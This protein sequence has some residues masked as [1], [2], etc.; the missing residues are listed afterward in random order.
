MCF[1]PIIISME[2]T[3][4]WCH[5]RNIT[6]QNSY[7][8]REQ[9]II[10]ESQAFS[11]RVDGKL[12]HH[13]AHS[14]LISLSLLLFCITHSM[15]QKERKKVPLLWIRKWKKKWKKQKC[16]GIQLWRHSHEKHMLCAKKTSQTPYTSRRS[17]DVI[18]LS[19]IF[20]IMQGFFLLHR[21]EGNAT[22]GLCMLLLL[23]MHTI[24]VEMGGDG[25]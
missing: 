19:L 5:E 18:F 22:R 21:S 3:E 24:M 23:Y 12:W 10:Y 2:L 20:I 16:F 15:T 1:F 7:F 25:V 14:F 11:L 6:L 9:K 17:N 8:E 13:R 4:R